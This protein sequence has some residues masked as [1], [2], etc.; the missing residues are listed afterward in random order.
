MYGEGQ[1]RELLHLLSPDNHSIKITEVNYGYIFCISNNI[2]LTLE[3]NPGETKK[4]TLFSLKELGVNRLSIGFQ[5]LDHGLLTTLSRTH[6]L[7][8]CFTMYEDARVAGFDNINIDMMYNIPEQSLDRWVDDLKTL[9]KLDCDHIAIFPLTSEKGTPFY[10]QVNSGEVKLPGS[11][12]EESMFTHSSQLLSKYGFIQYEVA[13]FSKPGK[14][15]QHNQHY[16]NLE[17]YLAFGPSAHGYD[18]KKRWWNVS[19]LDDYISKL[20]RN[21]KPVS[22]FETLSYTDRFNEAVMYGLRTNK[23]IS[24][25]IL[26]KYKSKVYLEYDLYGV[27]SSD[28]ISKKINSTQAVGGYLIKRNKKWSSQREELDPSLLKK[29]KNHLLFG[30]PQRSNFSYLIKNLRI[31]VNQNTNSSSKIV[32]ASSTNLLKFGDETYIRGFLGEFPTKNTFGNYKVKVENTTLNLVNNQFE[33][34]VRIPENKNTLDVQLFNDENKLIEQSKLDI[35]AINTA[36]HKFSFQPKYESVSLSKENQFKSKIVQLYFKNNSNHALITPLR[37]ND[38]ASLQSGVLNVT[39]EYEGC[40]ILLQDSLVNE[41]FSFGIKYNPR[42]IPKG[43]SEKD[44]FT[45]FF[46]KNSKSWIPVEKDSININKGIIYSSTKYGSGDYINGVIQTP[47]SP[48][49]NAFT[50]TKISDIEIANPSSNISIIA[51]PRPSQTG[52]ANLKYPIKTPTGRKG[53]SPSVTL[54]YN[55]EKQSGI[56]GY[57]WDL[58][59]SSININ[60]KWGIPDF[61]PNNETEL[62]NLAQDLGESNN[63]ATQHHEIVSQMEAMMKD[64]HA[65]NPNWKPR[66]AVSPK[67]PEPGDGKPRF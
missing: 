20:S 61:D 40:N 15:C 48:Q 9:V 63:L 54:S 19:S 27:T 34:F 60:S 39:D 64:A 14:E 67:Q 23:G 31:V 10:N 56:A 42:A 17:P 21:E 32:I 47:E 1:Q 6:R 25:E 12:I 36:E 35:T 38:L 4:E 7:D 62:Y 28:G 66:G 33:G 11:H 22:G 18:G 26:K 8:D 65:P 5:S 29:G 49:T 46:D 55:S 30:M 37:F 57:G 53:M 50:S 3:I 16:W 58:G 44:V 2:E 41:E 13:H 45:L 24:T 43:Y 59:F 51:A 52:E